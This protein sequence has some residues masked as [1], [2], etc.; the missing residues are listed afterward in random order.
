M[1]FSINFSFLQPIIS[2][3]KTIFHVDCVKKKLVKFWDQLQMNIQMWKFTCLRC[4]QA[5]ISPT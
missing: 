4:H 3:P 1:Y 2:N 5:I